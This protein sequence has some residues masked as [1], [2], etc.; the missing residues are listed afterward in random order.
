MGAQ[1]AKLVKI[2]MHCLYNYINA[3]QIRRIAGYYRAIF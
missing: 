2:N 3:W 1:V